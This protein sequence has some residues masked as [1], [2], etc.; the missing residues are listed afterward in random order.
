M[1][2]FLVFRHQIEI[3]HI[4]IPSTQ[5][6]EEN[7]KQIFKG[8]HSLFSKEKKICVCLCMGLLSKFLATSLAYSMLIRTLSLFCVPEIG[9]KFLPSIKCIPEVVK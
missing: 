8:F 1:L 4:S 3:V 2:L 6:L 9:L 7:K 5:N